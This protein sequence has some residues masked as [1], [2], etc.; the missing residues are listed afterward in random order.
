V[1][2][3]V[4]GGRRRERE[5]GRETGSDRNLEEVVYME[6]PKIQLNGW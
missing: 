3:C 1:L 6:W 2:N 4:V 5:R